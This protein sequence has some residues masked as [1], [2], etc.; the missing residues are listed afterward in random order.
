MR[1]VARVPPL[2]EKKK[3]P[4]RTISVRLDAEHVKMLERARVYYMWLQGKGEVTITDVIIAAIEM[5]LQDVQEEY[6]NKPSGGGLL[7]EDGPI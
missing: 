3:Q 5:M 7:D 2:R 1:A 4:K 6:R